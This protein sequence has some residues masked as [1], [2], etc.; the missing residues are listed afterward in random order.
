M[1]Y[2]TGRH[3]QSFKKINEVIDTFAGKTNVAMSG[4]LTNNEIE[5]FLSIPDISIVFA[6]KQ[7]IVDCIGSDVFFKKCDF[8]DIVVTKSEED[9]WH[10][11]IS[12]ELHV[13]FY[14]NDIDLS[15]SYNTNKD[16]VSVI[17]L[18]EFL[19]DDGKNITIFD[20]GQCS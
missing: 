10:I 18:I 11:N 4:F 12:E 6:I 19:A 20:K 3:T 8:K 9:N 17:T 1:K 14:V 15:I 5:N 16:E 13:Y 2:K 7:A